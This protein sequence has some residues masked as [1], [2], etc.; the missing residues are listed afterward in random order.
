[1]AQEEVDPQPLRADSGSVGEAALPARRRW[2][3]IASGL[4]LIL[5]VFAGLAW[6][7]RERIAG[8][9]I[10]GQLA[11]LG[12]AAT[13][14]IESIGP[15]RQVLRNVV[16]GDRRNP[17][18]TIERVETSLVP[19]FGTPG[20]GRVTLVKPRL[21]GS[22]HR[23][24]LSFGSLDPLIFTDS[25][26]PFRLPD[27]DLAIVDGRG[28]IES[29]FGPVGLKLVGKGHLRGGFAGEIAAI[30]P[31][32]A[33]GNCRIDRASVYG[34][35]AVKAEKPG[36][37]GPLRLGLLDCAS[38][39]R[40]ANA[41]AT[42]D[43]KL[44]QALDG[45]EGTLGLASD[46]L[47]LAEARFESLEGHSRFTLRDGNLT[48]RYDL[49]GEQLVSPQVHA[50]ALAFEGILRGTN[51]LARLD[52]EGTLKG[53]GIVL[54]DAVADGLAQ[55]EAASVGTLAAPVLEQL[56]AA[57]L[58]EGRGSSLGGSYLLRRSDKLVTLVVPSGTLRGGSG[59]ALL[60]LSRFQLSTG[61]EMPLRVSGN[62]ATG[63]NGL[64]RIAGRMER[65]QGGD[66]TMQVTMAEYRAGDARLALPRLMIV[67][68]SRGALGFA[69]E[70]RLSGGLP[71][72]RAE[73]LVLPLEGS[74]SE[75][76]GLAMWRKC[77]ELRFDRLAF[78]ELTLDRQRVTLCPPRGGAIVR[79]DRVG[80]RIAAGATGLGLAGKLGATPIRIASGPVGFAWPG[81][82]A[83]R[84]L[85]VTLGPAGTA[86]RF[87]IADLAAN[88]GSDVAGTFAGA[89]IRLD[90]VPLDILEASGRWR[91]AGGVLAIDEGALRLEDRQSDDRFQPLVAQGATLRLA[92][93][94]IEAEA[95]LR[96]PASSREVVRTD[97]R[98]DLSTARG[99]ADLFVDGVL[100]DESL[101]PD[102]VSR[103]ALGVIANARG[104]IRGKGRIDWNGEGVTSTGTFST[105]AFDFAA[106]FGPVQ[107]L[108][109]TLRFTDLLGLVSAPDQY[110][111]I[112]SMNPGIEV[113]D[114]RLVYEL[115][116]GLVLAVKSGAWPFLGG[117]LTLEPTQMNM[118]VAE[119]RRYTLTIEGLDAA[120]LAAHMDLENIA[121]TGT[122]DGV[123]P[124]VF[125]KDGGHV[126]AGHLESRPPGGNFSYV[127]ELTYKDLSPMAN[128]AFDAL[129]SLNY[130]EMRIDMDGSLEGEIVTRV[131]FDGI[132]QGEGA[133]RNFLTKKV[134]KLPIRFKVNIRAP[135]FQLA[136]SLRS[137]YDPAFVRDPRELG[138]L[139]GQ[140]R[141]RQPSAPAPTPDAADRPR[142]IQ[143][144]ESG[145]VP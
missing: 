11:K 12:I 136:T 53:S 112:S 103:L 30:A 44:R 8:N 73:N 142:R 92:D 140:G 64:P 83:A 141:P 80:T 14:E 119:D 99:S 87:R 51:G 61:D 100:F 94:R 10:A 52:T 123:L 104:V 41:S 60:S 121:V 102:E 35:V 101:Q 38:G 62:F 77:A 89:D 49:A 63:G 39:V 24:K 18:L 75:A 93:N 17:D 69:G 114:G 115:R 139:D 81:R 29:D 56:R 79:S 68:N 32:L 85:D 67:Q 129:K 125:D 130:R 74:W 105:D 90:A 117:E 59:Q 122:F 143:P 76:G 58:R 95:V 43:A 28:L 138:L 65:P 84:A 1:M 109:G 72:G 133:S 88:V 21:R 128:F 20:I 132:S 70:A 144:S 82:I 6:I 96:E 107:G 47:G 27:L 120:R 42:V 2:L 91:Y 86:A 37:K 22:Y 5:L 110:V 45:A 50:S 131:V 36:F 116:P 71:G 111:L 113:A 145:M 57:L 23:G 97:I 16:I 135:F 25:D 137:Y 126:V 124:L 98:H 34:S 26:E 33:I 108:S 134:A 4:A 55:A 15:R 31:A 40:L 48:A 19:R 106:A 54:G 13:Y 78:A 118:G 9:V 7:T 66:L 3:A 127:G 46:G